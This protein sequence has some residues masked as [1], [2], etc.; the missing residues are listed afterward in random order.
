MLLEQVIPEQFAFECIYLFTVLVG[1]IQPSTLS[2]PPFIHFHAVEEAG[3]WS[4][5]LT[6][7]PTHSYNLSVYPA[8]Q[9]AHPLCFSI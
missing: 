2:V 9:L 4:L 6:M 8:V 3:G 1:L 5:P 7:H